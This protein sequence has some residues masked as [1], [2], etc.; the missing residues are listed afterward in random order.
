MISIPSKY[1][2]HR[3]IPGSC[4]N[5]DFFTPHSKSR[6]GKKRIMF[7][8]SKNETIVGHGETPKPFH[9][10]D[11]TKPSSSNDR[12]HENGK[13]YGNILTAA[14]EVQAKET[15]IPSTIENDEFAIPIKLYSPAPT[16]RTIRAAVF[17][18]HGGMFSLG[19]RDSHPTIARALA[20]FGLVVATASFRNGSEAPNK[21]NITMR[22]LQDV[23][24]YMRREW[25]DVPFGLVGSSSVSLSSF[26]N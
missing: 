5:P 7:D 18:I 4:R 12:V 21:S 24:D 11:E 1:R 26:G 25:R 20:R 3:Q 22:D 9:P 14:V 16:T 17:F 2:H 6:V 15:T 19:D 13:G 8:V 23:I 10:R